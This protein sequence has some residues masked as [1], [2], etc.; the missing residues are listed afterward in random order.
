LSI[1]IDY[2]NLTPKADPILHGN[3]LSM[4]VFEVKVF[5]DSRLVITPI[6]GEP[7]VLVVAWL[8]WGWRLG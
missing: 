1:T 3:L 7:V 8:L 6:Y 5:P 4:I 2:L